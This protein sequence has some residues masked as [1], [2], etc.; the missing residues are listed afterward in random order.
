VKS[1]QVIT[2]G[3]VQFQAKLIFPN[4]SYCSKQWWIPV[5]YPTALD[6]SW[7]AVEKGGYL[8]DGSMQLVAGTGNVSGTVSRMDWQYK[9]G[10]SC[11]Y[12]TQAGDTDYAPI[13]IFE[14]QTARNGNYFLN[15]R[16][17]TWW[18][19]SDASKCSYSWS[20][21]RFFLEPHDGIPD[22][23]KKTYVPERL[24]YLLYDPKQ[25]VV[26]CLEGA[27]IQ[28]GVVNVI[29]DVSVKLYLPSGINLAQHSVGIYASVL[30]Y[31]GG[32]S[33]SP[34]S[35]G[36][37]SISSN[38]V[39]LF[40][41]VCSPLILPSFPLTLIHHG[42]EDQCAD[43]ETMHF[44]EIS[45]LLIVTPVTSSCGSSD[46]V[47]IAYTS[48]PTGQPT[49]TPSPL[50]RNESAPP[51]PLPSFLQNVTSSTNDRVPEKKSPDFLLAIVLAGI[52]ISVIATVAVVSRVFLVKVPGELLGTEV[53]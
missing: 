16:T 53:V 34:T 24:G 3:V 45:S 18:Y 11:N 39:Y 5:D 20:T 30:G 7:L 42:Q 9:F 26:D 8:L 6:V 23:A 10:S 41:Q 33:I 12:P 28:F 27:K 14:L 15:V 25:Q 22:E 38:E 29:S 31:H 37:T 13:G 2:N 46:P 21:G 17:T 36:D 35:Y 19:K 51:T 44:E 49:P 1:L 40:L 32:D 43:E 47:I 48:P 52:I 50:L 4:D